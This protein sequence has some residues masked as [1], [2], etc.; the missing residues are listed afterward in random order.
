MTFWCA[1]VAWR[2]KWFNMVVMSCGICGQK[3][4]RRYLIISALH[5]LF[6]V[7]ALKGKWRSIINIPYA[8]MDVLQNLPPSARLDGYIAPPSGVIKLKTDARV[9]D[10]GWIGLGVAA[11]DS[12][13][14]VCFDA[15][16]CIR[17]YW[18]LK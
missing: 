2:N 15:M 5:H 17:A 11:R 10:D 13:V 9:C 7:K 16:R 1:G 6:Y 18:P 4:T 14:Y 12:T 8:F 3:E